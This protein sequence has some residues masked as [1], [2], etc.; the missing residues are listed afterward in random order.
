MKL[1]TVGI[2]CTSRIQIAGTTMYRTLYLP[3][4]LALTAVSWSNCQAAGS[5][6]T[7][8]AF[9]K[10]VVSTGYSTAPSSL[11]LGHSTVAAEFGCGRGRIRDAVT[12]GCR[13]PADIR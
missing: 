8:P 5:F 12:P 3:V 4:I 7:R 11:T 13:G 9:S 1:P 2:S 6:Q 10:T